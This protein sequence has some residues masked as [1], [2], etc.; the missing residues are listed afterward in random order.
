MAV[1]TVYGR[2]LGKLNIFAA[3]VNFH[4][5]IP[6]YILYLQETRGLSLATI[7]LMEGLGWVAT[8]LAEVPTGAIADRYGRRVSLLIG[9]LT[10]GPAM[11][12][13]GLVGYF[14]LLMTL[15]LVWNFTM[16]FHSAADQALLYDS[17]EAEG[18]GGE[19]SRRMG[20]QLGIGQ[21]SRA[22]AGLVGASL[23]VFS[24]ELPFVLCGI[25][26]CAAGLLALTMHEPPRAG[27]SVAP[28]SETVEATVAATVAAGEKAAGQS[29]EPPSYWGT[30]RAAFRIAA[31]RPDVRK[32][33]IYTS[34]LAT[35]PFCFTFFFVQPYVSAAGLSVYWL[36]PVFVGIQVA[37]IVGSLLSHRVASEVGE[38]G[39]LYGLPLLLVALLT[40]LA[41]VPVTVGAGLL[42]GINLVWMICTPVLSGL[43]NR[44]IPSEQRATLLSLQAL[45]RTL[46][47]AAGTPFLGSF[48]EKF[49]WL[50]LALG[51]AALVV[52]IPGTL[53]LL[54]LARAA[55]PRVMRV[56]TV[57]GAADA[58]GTM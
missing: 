43:L 17:L 37:G 55:A 34:F 19:F 20:R 35:V 23:A 2:N 53:L 57:V 52:L 12:G 42:A 3:L 25:A 56:Q 48:F 54:G 10:L 4:L 27:E 44:L 32:L 29:P 51:M 38:R 15:H 21:A 31:G 28:A 13:Y 50:P 58:D 1:S 11:I 45:L 8:A 47:L 24:T 41:F 18:R 33:M 49:G 5:W 40:V 9:G 30:L 46:W 16:G 39:I 6:V 22:V 36:G 7:A 14:P 26:V